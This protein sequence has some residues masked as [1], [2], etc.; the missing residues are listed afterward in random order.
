MRLPTSFLYIITVLIWGT[1]WFAMEFQLVI[2]FEL[3]I[4]YA[5]RWRRRCSSAIA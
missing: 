5:L 4:L 3:A 1:S 2:P